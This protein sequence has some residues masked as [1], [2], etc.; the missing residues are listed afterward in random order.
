[1]GSSSLYLCDLGQALNIS[2]PQFS[3]CKTRSI[4]LLHQGVSVM[5]RVWGQR[6]STVQGSNDYFSYCLLLS[7]RYSSWGPH[8]IRKAFARVSCPPILAPRGKGRASRKQVRCSARTPSPRMASTTFLPK[9]APSQG[10]GWEEYDKDLP[11]H[12]L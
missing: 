10:C 3:I 6:A 4:S 8:P 7:H 11:L 9:L 1:M 12:V 2:K 5:R